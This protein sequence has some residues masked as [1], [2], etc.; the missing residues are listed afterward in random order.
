ML[1][2]YESLDSITTV[3]SNGCCLSSSHRLVLGLLNGAMGT[4]RVLVPELAGK[5]GV[6]SAMSYFSGAK[7]IGMTFGPACGGLF[8]E[9]AQH[10]PSVFS[11]TGL[12]GR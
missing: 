5:D 6:V 3:V 10:Y 1:Q 12:F 8:A 11:A 4:G 2:T 7:A 9:P